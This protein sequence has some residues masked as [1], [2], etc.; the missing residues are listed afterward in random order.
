MKQLVAYITAGFP[1]QNFSLDLVSALKEAGVDK[2][3]LGIPFS[4]PVADGPIIEVANLHALQNGFKMETLFEI[5]SVVAPKIETYWMGY[6]NPFYHKGVEVF[7]QKAAEFGVKGFIIPDLPHEEALP[8][9]SLM[10]QYKLSLISFVAPTDSKERIAK[11]VKDAKGFIYLVAY[12]GITGAH[13]SED[14]TKTIQMIKEQSSTPLFVGFGVNE[15]TAK[16]RARGVDGVIVGSAFVEVL[17]NEGLSG[18]E[19]IAMIA[20]KAKIIKEKINA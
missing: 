20:Q 8:Y 10:E 18:S 19:K 6:F 14:L 16:E 4:D 5:S 15:K 3:E 7:A 12:A 13:S 1:D 9:V 11:V 2:L 17:L